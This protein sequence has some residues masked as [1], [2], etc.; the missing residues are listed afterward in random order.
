MGGDR[1]LAPLTERTW[2][3][4][5]IQFRAS[6]PGRRATT[7]SSSTANWSTPAAEISLIAPGSTSAQIDVGLLR[8]P[9]RV[10][11][12]SEIRL[13]AASLESVEP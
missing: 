3:D 1:F 6:E 8:D 4:V 11:G 7:R 5:A 2:H 9:T 12:T 13:D 10:Q